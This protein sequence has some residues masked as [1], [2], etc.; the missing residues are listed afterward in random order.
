MLGEARAAPAQEG[1]FYGILDVSRVFERGMEKN[2]TCIE[3]YVG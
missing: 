3:V 1:V 2:G